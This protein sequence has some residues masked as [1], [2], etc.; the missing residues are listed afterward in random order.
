[1]LRVLLHIYFNNIGKIIWIKLD[2]MN[3]CIFI[4]TANN[5]TDGI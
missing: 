1:M 5:S 4:C 2:V 3:I